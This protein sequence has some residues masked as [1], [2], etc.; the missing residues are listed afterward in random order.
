MKAPEVTRYR[1]NARTLF[2]DC[3]NVAT[4]QQMVFMKSHP[5]KAAVNA[6]VGIDTTA[7]LT[8]QLRF[9]QEEL[10]LPFLLIPKATK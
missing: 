1:D 3:T 7:R 10:S 9:Y 5:E 2:T 8:P 6:V 4:S